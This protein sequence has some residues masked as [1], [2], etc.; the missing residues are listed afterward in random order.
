MLCLCI[1]LSESLKKFPCCGPVLSYYCD[2]IITIRVPCGANKVK[3][4]C[5]Q[6]RCKRLN[7]FELRNYDKYT[8]IHMSGKAVGGVSR[9]S[10]F[11]CT[12]FTLGFFSIASPVILPL[13]SGRLP[14]GEP[15]WALA[16]F[17]QPSATNSDAQSGFS[18]P[19]SIRWIQMDSA[20]PRRNVQF[21]PARS[22][23][24]QRINFQHCDPP[25][26]LSE[27]QAS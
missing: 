19:V 22:R 24:Y 11:S 17:S 5:T 15:E 2:C 8:F 10:P 16:G 21:Q 20:N 9:I 13:L 7:S 18:Q 3:D 1:R 14:V 26:H 25:T 6:S 12:F 27:K 4:P 23:W